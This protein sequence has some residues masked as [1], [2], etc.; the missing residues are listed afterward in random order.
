VTTF[1]VPTRPQAY[2]RDWPIL[3]SGAGTVAAEES[4][5][6]GEAISY[7]VF[8][9]CRPA[10]CHWH[11]CSSRCEGA[12]RH[13][14]RG[15]GT[16]A[17]A[18]GPAGDCFAAAIGCSKSEWTRRYCLRC[19]RPTPPRSKTR[20]AT[21]ASQ[22]MGVSRRGRCN[23][24]TRRGTPVSG[25]PT[26]HLQALSRT[27]RPGCRRHQTAGRKL[28]LPGLTRDTSYVI[29]GLTTAHSRA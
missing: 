23:G 13:G 26:C 21:P 24:M 16:G 14:C 12:A 25:R 8:R 7:S 22:G 10:G 27:A 18:V 17:R 20:A 19:D 9:C 2:P 1:V 11:C 28:S 3:P 5:D 6:V 29:R 4:G 15:A